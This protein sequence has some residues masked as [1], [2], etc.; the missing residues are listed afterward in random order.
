MS[1]LQLD[2]RGMQVLGCME[3]GGQWGCKVL[4][5]FFRRPCTWV[6]MMSLA[7]E[8]LARLNPQGCGMPMEDCDHGVI[9]YTG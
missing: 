5:D 4:L 9:S 1:M 7:T 2:V 6:S 8:G 3:R